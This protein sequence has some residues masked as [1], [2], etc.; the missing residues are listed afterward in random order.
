MSHLLYPTIGGSPKTPGNG[1]AFT[2]RDASTYRSASTG[3]PSARGASTP[4]R[5][6]CP[7][8][9]RSIDQSK[10]F[11]IALGHVKRA[12]ARDGS[13]EMF[14]ETLSAHYSAG[15]WRRESWRTAGELGV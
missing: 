9:N 15:V 12:Q 14:T 8:C 2:P 3:H 5:R 10:Q 11:L 7:H 4:K 1:G 6:Q 13:R